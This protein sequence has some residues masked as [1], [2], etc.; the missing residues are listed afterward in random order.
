L[1]ALSDVD[2][3]LVFKELDVGVSDFELFARFEDQTQE[4]LLNDGLGQLTVV[5]GLPVP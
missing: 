4:L 3:S 5:L 2:F 1:F